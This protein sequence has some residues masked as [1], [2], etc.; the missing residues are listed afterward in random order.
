[1]SKRELFKQCNFLQLCLE[2]K[3]NKRNTNIT[4]NEKVGNISNCSTIHKH[5][6]AVFFVFPQEVSHARVSKSE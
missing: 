6:K 4:N 2:N 3:E 5:N 1:M